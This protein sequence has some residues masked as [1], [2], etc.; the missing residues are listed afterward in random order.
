M[1][2]RLFVYKLDLTAV[3]EALPIQNGPEER[4]AVEGLVLPEHVLGC[5]S[6]VL[7][8][9]LPV[10]DVGRVTDQRERE[11]SNVSPS[12]HILTCLHKLGR[13]GGSVGGE[14]RRG[15]RGGQ[16]RGEEGR[17][18][19][20]RESLLNPKTAKTYRNTMSKLLLHDLIAI[21][22]NPFTP[23]TLS[24][25]TS[26]LLVRLRP[27]SLKKAVLGITPIPTMAMSASTTLLP[28]PTATPVSLPSWP[29]NS[30]RPTPNSNLTFPCSSWN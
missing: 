27:E 9:Q 6:P 13:G 5:H 19:E 22:K 21:G 3:S 24:T 23:L 12:K 16:E 30:F 17:G 15:R 28:S 10:A 20:G 11:A 7:V 18:G 26:P 2:A 8:C 29:T 14:R 4:D 1:C 25:I